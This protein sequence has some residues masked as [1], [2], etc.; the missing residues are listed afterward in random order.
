MPMDVISYTKLRNELARMIDKVNNDHVP[1]VITRKGTEGAVLVS[2]DYFESL[3][4]TAYA[5]ST[6]S[7]AVQIKKALAEL[8]AGKGI[9]DSG[10]RP[11]ST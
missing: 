3:N 11:S 1:V 9:P 4:E 8:R 2:K 5:L 6:R 10:Q 7:N